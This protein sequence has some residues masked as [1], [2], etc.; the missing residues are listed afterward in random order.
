MPYSPQHRA[1]TKKRITEAARQQFNLHGYDGVSIDQ[2]MQAANLSRGGFYH[3]FKN[4]EA[5]FAAA[6]DSFCAALSDT[7]EKESM[8]NGPAVIEAFLDGYL[9]DTHLEDAKDQ[10]PM[11]AVPSDVA[12]RGPAVKQAYQNVL[13]TMLRL[14]EDNAPAKS[15]EAALTMCLISVGGMV[16]ARSITDEALQKELRAAARSVSGRLGMTT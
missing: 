2:I 7:I 16:L 5:L 10:C 8:P 4:K 13:E 11:I 3:H 9:S 14:F 15:R 12:R 6:V 1:K